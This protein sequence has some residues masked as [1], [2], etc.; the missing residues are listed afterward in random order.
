LVFKV[1]MFIFYVLLLYLVYSFM[2]IANPP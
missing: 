2:L 1:S